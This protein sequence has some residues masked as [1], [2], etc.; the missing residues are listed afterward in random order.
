MTGVLRAA[1]K[2]LAHC[3]RLIASE[4][5]PHIH[6]PALAFSVALLELLAL[7]GHGVDEGW[8][9]AVGGLIAVDHYAVGFL[10]AL[11]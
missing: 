11:S 7:R 6:H 3:N 9:E 8:T 5:L 4:S 2:L 10:E 1:L